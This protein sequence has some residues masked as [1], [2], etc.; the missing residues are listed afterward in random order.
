MKVGWLKEVRSKIFKTRDKE[1]FER[2]FGENTIGNNNVF[3][4]V[5]WPKQLKNN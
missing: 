2:T 5:F 1:I 4:I 3:S